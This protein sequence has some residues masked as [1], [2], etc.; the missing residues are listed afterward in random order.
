MGKTAG[1]AVWLDPNKTSPYDF[2]QYWRNVDDADVH[3]M[4][5]D[6]D[7]CAA[8]GNR[9]SLNRSEGSQ[10]N[11]VKERLAWEVTA[12]IHG[13]EE[14]DQ[15]Q[16]AARAVFSGAGSSEN[17]PSTEL[18]RDELADGMAVLE[19]MLRCGLIASK[20]EGRRLIQQGGVSIDGEKV[21][22]PAAAVPAAAFEKGHVVLKKGKKVFHKAIVK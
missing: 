18:S 19:L 17:M 13:K 11:A 20:G 15:A 7:L 5:E 14:A 6:A 9:S 4:P 10:L 21:D 12:L 8:G 16:T 1:G 3:Q 22:D 2:Y